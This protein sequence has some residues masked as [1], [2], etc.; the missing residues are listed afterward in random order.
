[1]S[2]TFKEE[3][4]WLIGFTEKS[5]EDCRKESKRYLDFECEERKNVNIFGKQ[6]H[7]DKIENYTQH[8]FFESGV[9]CGFTIMLGELKR[10]EII[11][12]NEYGS[13]E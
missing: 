9:A 11:Y 2:M 13:G 4:D 8:Q 12:K 10:L 7:P 6:K 5:V 3:L 1:M